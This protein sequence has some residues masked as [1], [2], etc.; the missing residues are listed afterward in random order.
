MKKRDDDKRM[1]VR[2]PTDL[3]DEI[4]VYL[5][6]SGMPFTEF[7]RRAC[8]EKLDREAG[9]DATD[10]DGQIKQAIYEVLKEM[11]YKDRRGE[12]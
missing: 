11:G 5:S 10:Q 9:R 12:A 2:L 6:S 8:R 7:L 1:T 4:E 3:A